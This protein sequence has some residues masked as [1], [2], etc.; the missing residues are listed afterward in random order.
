MSGS[1][2]PTH[3]ALAAVLRPLTERGI[4]GAA[5]ACL[6]R[7]GAPVEHAIGLADRVAETP[8]TP[9]SQFRIASVTKTFVSAV[10]LQLH[11]ERIVD[12]D[13]PLAR[14]LPELGHADTVTL[15][16][17]LTHT[18]G[19]PLYSHY[20]LDEFPP[21][22]SLWT[23]MELIRRAYE[24]T[25]PGPPGG[26]F[27]YANVGSKVLGRVIELA[28]G[29]SL[30]EQLQTRLLTPLGL[31]NT[32]PSGAEGPLPDRLA[33]GYYLDAES[34]GTAPLDVTDRVPP[35]FLWSG[36]DMYSTAADLAR[37]TRA[38][39]AGPALP[40]SLRE[41]LFS[42]LVSGSFPGSCLSHHGLGV[43]VFERDGRRIFGYRGSTPGYVGIVGYDPDS[44]A[45]VALQ[46]NSFSPDPASPYRAAVEPV[47]FA[48][49]ALMAGAG[50]LP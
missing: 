5:I 22:D 45:A 3:E 10:V 20:R 30:G 9:A 47:L 44:G 7:D 31:A 29:R 34:D 19:L 12:I 17:I 28:T 27:E 8:L 26:P 41:R 39:F 4:I 50:P 49:L 37:W 36:G 42:D 18:G 23:P 24:N 11:H 48:A 25:P 15:Y 35:S 16:Q 46:T 32:V 14:W 38:L 40:E 1:T 33:R 13:A 6:N 2:T 43:M 21:A